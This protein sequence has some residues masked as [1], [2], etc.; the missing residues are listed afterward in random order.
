[1]SHSLLVIGRAHETLTSLVD[2]E[3]GYR[4][5]LITG[6]DEFLE[7]YD[8]GRRAAI[9]GIAELE[10]LTADNP[11][12]L[13][14]WQVLRTY[15]GSGSATS[16][17]RTSRCGATSAGHRSQDEVEALVAS[18]EG[19]R[20]TDEMRAIVDEAIRVEQGLLESRQQVSGAARERLLL[21][22]LVGTL[23]A[24]GLALL[25]ATLLTTNIAGGVGR[26]A[27]SGPPDR[28]LATLTYAPASIAKTRSA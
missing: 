13:A 10:D 28:L 2:M 25:L 11:G 14:R 12:Q 19:K 9:E 16:P 26:L 27:A 1:M 15:S 21:V 23:I 24:V 22:L 8:E 20:R 18:G 6:R 4:G 5:F 17:I 3:T 7:P